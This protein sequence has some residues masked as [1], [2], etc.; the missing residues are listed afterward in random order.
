MRLHLVMIPARER[1]LSA[2]A[3]SCV[4]S[5]CLLIDEHVVLTGPRIQGRRVLWV[6]DICCFKVWYVRFSSKL[7]AVFMMLG[8]F[9]LISI[10]LRKLLL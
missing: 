10:L 8:L 9:L 7:E 6:D 5:V 2:E 1:A 3:N 4:W